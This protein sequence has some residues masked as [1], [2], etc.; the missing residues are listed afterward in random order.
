MKDRNKI[1]NTMLDLYQQRDRAE[2]MAELYGDKG[3]LIE[4]LVWQQAAE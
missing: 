1:M 4:M 2:D 3:D